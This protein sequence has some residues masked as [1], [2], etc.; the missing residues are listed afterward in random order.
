MLNAK[1]H[2]LALYV[3]AV[4]TLAAPLVAEAQSTVDEQQLVLAH[5]QTDSRAI[6]LKSMDLD[7]TQVEAFMPLY[8]AYQLA[9]KKI[10]DRVVALMISFASDYDSMT[11]TEARHLLKSWF[12]L[13]DDEDRL[14]EGYA[15]KM[16]KVL[17][18]AKVLRWV[19]IENR[20]STELRL[21]AVRR[22]PL[23]K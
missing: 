21:S 3:A 9:Y 10:M 4:A 2:A 23:A 15:R 16:D 12:D 18:S 7:E 14:L 11:D 13:K 22:I 20:L 6:V 8:D 5:I 17:P 1:N 19:Q